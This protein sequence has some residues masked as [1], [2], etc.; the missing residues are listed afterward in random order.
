MYPVPA[1]WPTRNFIIEIL[2]P[3]VSPPD[4]HEK[5]D[6]TTWPSVR[7]LSFPSPETEK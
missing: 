3:P 4:L 2:T 6:R 7:N 1:P 5:P